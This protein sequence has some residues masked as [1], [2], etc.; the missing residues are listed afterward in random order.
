VRADDPDVFG[1]ARLRAA[2]DVTEASKISVS[3]VRITRSRLLTWYWLLAAWPFVSLVALLVYSM[4]R[5]PGNIPRPAATVVQ[6]LWRG[7]LAASVISV[8]SSPI[9]LRRSAFSAG[10]AP[11]SVWA[12]MLALCAS[13]AFQAVCEFVLFQPL[14]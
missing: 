13:T 5:P 12:A 9:A 8:V 14:G 1:R 6:W 11:F 2:P 7:I 4:I 10:R 3:P